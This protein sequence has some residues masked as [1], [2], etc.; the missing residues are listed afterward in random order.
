MQQAMISSRSTGSNVASLQQ[1]SLDTS[2][3]TIAGYTGSRCTTSNDN[4][5]R[6]FDHCNTLIIFRYTKEHIKRK[7]SK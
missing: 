3:G 4:Y 2:K 1:Q 5:I 7:I 6:L